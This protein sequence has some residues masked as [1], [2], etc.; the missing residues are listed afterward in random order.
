M[1]TATVRYGWDGQIIGSNLRPGEINLGN[2]QQIDYQFFFSRLI[3]SYQLSAKHTIDFSQMH[4]EQHRKGSDPLGAISAIERIDVLGVPA[5]Y[6]KITLAL[7][8]VQ[9]G[10]VITWKVSLP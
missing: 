9:A 6:Q 3:A 7:G 10:L 5:V 1:D 4:Y 2:N 8:F